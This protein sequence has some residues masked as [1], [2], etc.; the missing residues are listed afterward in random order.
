MSCRRHQLPCSFAKSPIL[1][2]LRALDY[3]FFSVKCC[4]EHANVHYANAGIVSTCSTIC[5]ADTSCQPLNTCRELMRHL[6]T[7]P[8]QPPDSLTRG[9]DP[10][11]RQPT[12]ATPHRRSERHC[13]SR[14]RASHSLTSAARTALQLATPPHSSNLPL[15]ARRKQQASLHSSRISIDP[16]RGAADLPAHPCRTPLQPHQPVRQNYPRRCRQRR[17]ASGSVEDGRQLTP[18]ASGPLQRLRGG[19]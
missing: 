7:S 3:S 19:S 5:A 1:I 12:A 8:Q 15:Q 11:G 13:S 17:W 18:Q 4:S 16:T 14:C 2:T 10:P 9:A 6:C